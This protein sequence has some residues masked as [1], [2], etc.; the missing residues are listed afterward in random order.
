MFERN[1]KSGISSCNPSKGEGG[2]V[3]TSLQKL[4]MFVPPQWAKIISSRFG[5]KTRT[6]LSNLVLISKQVCILQGASIDCD[7]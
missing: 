3:V 4:Y 1:S 2:E 5:L 7:Y 6:D